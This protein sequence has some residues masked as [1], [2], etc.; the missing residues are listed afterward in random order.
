MM[1]VVGSVCE[2]KT[3]GVFG[4]G[5]GSRGVQRMQIDCSGSAACGSD[6]GGLWWWGIRPSAT[7]SESAVMNTLSPI[8]VDE[9][10]GDRHLINQLREEVGAAKRALAGK[11]R[12]SVLQLEIAAQVHRSLL[13]SPIRHPR[14]NVDVRYLPIEA[15]GGDYCQVRFPGPSSCY[16][17]MCD[18]APVVHTDA[19]QRLVFQRGGRPRSVVFHASSCD[20]FVEPDI[21]A[22]PVINPG[23][24]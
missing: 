1:T 3:I 7:F 16:V 4:I 24:R 11:Q 22:N 10:L 14:I 2:Q 15:V 13:P 18:V 9:A 23:L 21:S 8:D 12:E 20:S 17:T 19:G 5:R 6:F